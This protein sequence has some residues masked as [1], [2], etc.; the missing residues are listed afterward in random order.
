MEVVQ[1][2][3]PTRA[4]ASDPI[5]PSKSE[6]I[7]SLTADVSNHLTADVSEI[8]GVDTCRPGHYSSVILDPSQPPQIPPGGPDFPAEARAVFRGATSLHSLRAAI[9]TFAKA[10]APQLGYSPIRA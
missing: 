7:S 3:R 9:Q 10:L 6:V 5:Q 2:L 4:C 1:K 8:L